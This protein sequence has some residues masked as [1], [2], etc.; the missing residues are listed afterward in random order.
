MTRYLAQLESDCLWFPPAQSALQEPNGL[1]AIGGDL[2]PARLLYAYRHGIFPWYGAHHPI[3]WWSPDP[4]GVLI[5]AQIHASRSLLRTLKRQ[6][7]YE[8]W[9]NRD[10]MAVVHACAAPRRDSEETWINADLMNSYAVLHAQGLAHSVEVWQ[11]SQLI[12]GLYGIGIGRLFC[13]ESMFSRAT[14]ASKLA[15]YVLSRHFGQHGGQLIDCQMQTEHLASLGCEEWPRSRFIEAL[16]Q[17][18][19]QTVSPGCWTH[20]RIQP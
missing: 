4:R 1:L 13:G 5:P 2:T 9:I 8:F 12:G 11:G 20:Q 19:D 10:F 16:S 3:L 15:L 18:R 14:D 6:P 17:W 7:D